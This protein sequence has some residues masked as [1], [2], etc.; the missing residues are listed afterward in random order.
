MFFFAESKDTEQKAYK[1][2]NSSVMKDITTI[3]GRKFY[4]Y[5]EH[6]EKNTIFNLSCKYCDK[7]FAS[8]WNLEDLE[9]HLQRLHTNHHL[10]C[11][12]FCG[13]TFCTTGRLYEHVICNHKNGQIKNDEP[14][15]GV[16]KKRSNQIAECKTQSKELTMHMRYLKRHILT[17]K[18]KLEIQLQNDIKV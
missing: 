14:L 4:C 11:C 7:K 18:S 13:K 8:I 16:R 6:Q 5:Q 12:R 3:R 17:K 15:L 2:P 1:K 9:D 10:L